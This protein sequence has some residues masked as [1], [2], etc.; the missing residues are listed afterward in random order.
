MATAALGIDEYNHRYRTSEREVSRCEDLVRLLPKGRRSV[1]EIGPYDGFLTSILTRYFADVTTVDIAPSSFKIPGV[2]SFVGDVRKLDFEDGSFDCVVCTEVLEHVASIEQ[3]CKEIARV[4]RHEIVVGVP[5]NQDIR[6]GRTTCLGCGQ[7]SP[8]WGHVNSIDD[9]RLAEL[10][11]PLAPRAKSFVGT[12]KSQTTALAAQL[13][14]W[15]GNPWG[16]YGPNQSCLRC[17]SVLTAAPNRAFWQKPLGFAA[18][19]LM[20]AKIRTAPPKP[21]WIHLVFAK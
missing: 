1:L 15:A 17:N 2:R 11:R 19:K 10:F 3:A 14:D 18:A 20:E 9:V 7:K 5:F 4:A 13:M 8:P 6:V 12:E 16:A 21:I